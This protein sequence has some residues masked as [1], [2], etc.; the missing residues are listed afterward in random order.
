MTKI[1]EDNEM[2][3]AKDKDEILEHGKIIETSLREALGDRYLAYALSTIKSRS[4]PDVRDG[5]KPVH[6]RLLYAMKQLRVDPET[7]PKK[8]A[9]IVG[10]VM[11]K[12]HPHGDTAIYDAMVRLAQDFSSRYPLVDGQG[13][14]GNVDGDNAAAMRYTEAKLTPVAKLLL[15]GIDED[16]VDFR[17]TYDGDGKEPVVLPSNFPN[18]LANGA[19]GIAVGMA[20]SIPPHNVAEIAGAL[21]ILLKKPSATTA[22]LMASFKGPDFPLGGLMAESPEAIQ[23]AYETGKG[24]FRIRARWEKEDLGQGM[25]QLVITEIP[26]MVQKSKL[27]ERI[28]DLLQTRKIPILDDVRDESTEDIRVVLIPKSRNV[29]PEILMGLLYKNSD[30]E[31]RFSMNLNVIDK[32]NAPKVMNLPEVLQ[33][34]INHRL[35]VLL[36]RNK[37][38]LAKI[39]HRLEILAGLLV[40]YLNID[41]VIAIIRFEDEP[42]QVLMSEFKLSEVQADAILNMRLKALH[43]LEE[44]VIQTEHDELSKEKA[45]IEAL[46]ADESL[47]KKALTDEFK[48]LE[49][50]FSEKTDLGKRR[51]EIIGAVSEINVPVEALIEKESVTVFCSAK[52]WIRAVKGHL[53]DV[54]IKDVKYK[55]GDKEKFVIKT[56]TIDKL[57]MLHSDGR[58]YTMAVDKLPRGRGYGEP[59]SLLCEFNGTPQIQ[60]IHSYKKGDVYIVAASD[61]R[62]FQVEADNL[63]A[64]TKNGRQVLNVA[65]NAR[66][67]VL[68]K[69]TGDHVAVIGNNRKLLIFPLEQLPIMNRGR[70]VILQKYKDASLSDIKTFKKEEGLS[71]QLGDRTRT[72]EDLLGW[73]GNRAGVGKMPPN[74]FPKENRF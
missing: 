33:H 37:H 69:V 4:L 27:I 42:K 11:G 64:S 50:L 54:A 49:K 73:M 58:V 47:Q 67:R 34:Y 14:F 55:E 46:I 72:Q 62:G 71:W 16:A 7:M 9:R 25:W 65:Q 21:R 66:A 17:E 56:E 74:G 26:Y 70:G 32:N 51:T 6:R 44:L 45:E 3:K 35:E 5:L 2:S 28:A 19:T 18:L 57:L 43:K 59:L 13:N 29:D 24:S 31:S 12:Y 10:D 48:N 23:H 20:T 22:D 41:R 61:G 36:R 63:L 53:N 8:S 40:A 1:L 30:L 39:D 15:E 52:G 68:A 38:R 60:N